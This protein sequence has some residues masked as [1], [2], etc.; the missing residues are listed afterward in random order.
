[1]ASDDAM[2][3]ETATQG[4]YMDVEQQVTTNAGSPAESPR[5]SSN[6]TPGEQ[7]QPRAN[8]GHVPAEIADIILMARRVLVAFMRERKAED[9]VPDNS[10]VVVVDGNVRL[11]YA[12]RALLENG[13]FT[14]C[15][16]VCV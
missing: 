15:L 8:D 12:F 7:V 2:D 13:T 3:V 6:E 14:R 10:R 4:L 16:T 11:R 9:I 5:S 1:M